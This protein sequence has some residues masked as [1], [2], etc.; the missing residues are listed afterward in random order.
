MDD[1]NFPEGVKSDDVLPSLDDCAEAF[2]D[3]QDKEGFGG[4][5]IYAAADKAL[6][7][8][9]HRN[10]ALSIALD[11]ASD[12]NIAYRKALWRIENRL[13]SLISFCEHGNT[14]PAETVSKDALEIVR[15]M[16]GPVPT[17]PVEA[18]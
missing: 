1:P 3:Y 6:D 14:R 18:A 9:C 10:L 13:Q 4:H 15:E 7:L 11:E 2:A 8:I 17:Q 16:L 5:K 12:R